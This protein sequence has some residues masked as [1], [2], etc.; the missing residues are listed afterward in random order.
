MTRLPI[1]MLPHVLPDDAAW[2]VIVDRYD[3]YEGPSVSYF[4]RRV[5]AE[6]E[7]KACEGTAAVV[8]LAE[9][10]RRKD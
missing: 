1:P 2:V 4:A 7:R 9:V 8:L 10:V 3:P 5:D 6:E